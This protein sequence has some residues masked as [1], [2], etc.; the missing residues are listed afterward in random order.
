MTDGKRD[1]LKKRLWALDVRRGDLRRW[2]EVIEFS[3]I[4]IPDAFVK[5]LDDMEKEALSIVN[6]N[7]GSV[8]GLRD[9]FSPWMVKGRDIVLCRKGRIVGHDALKR[10]FDYLDVEW[11]EKVTDNGEVVVSVRS[12]S[13]P[14][15]SMAFMFGADRKLRRVVV[16]G[17]MSVSVTA[18]GRHIGKE[19]GTDGMV[20]TLTMKE[21]DDDVGCVWIGDR[22][23]VEI[24]TMLS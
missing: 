13:A 3:G 7:G 17:M 15:G 2:K 12:L 10:L 18:I 5:E 4:D 24:R 11:M 21:G 14:D 1:D 20:Y 9:E 6:E 23:K 22:K 8:E 16:P 19:R